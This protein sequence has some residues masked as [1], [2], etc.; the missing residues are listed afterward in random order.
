MRNII[1]KRRKKKKRKDKVFALDW[2]A[3]FGF[4]PSKLDLSELALEPGIGDEDP[5]EPRHDFPLN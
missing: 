1:K 5:D 3:Y 2:I 4:E